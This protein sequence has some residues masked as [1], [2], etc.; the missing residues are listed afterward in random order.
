MVVHQAEADDLD[1]VVR[2]ESAKT[3]GYPVDSGDKLDRGGKEDIILQAFGG[4]V[5]VKK[6]N[7]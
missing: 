3:K 7:A 4:V 2:S 5:I 1:G 6:P